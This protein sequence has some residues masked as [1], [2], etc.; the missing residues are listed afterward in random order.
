VAHSEIDLSRA[1][2]AIT[3]GAR[4]IGRATALAFARRG[5]RVAIGDLDVE[6]AREAAAAI[7]QATEATGHSTEPL[8]RPIEALGHATEALA[9]DVTS[10]DSF[11]A[12]VDAVQER[13]GPI[14]VLV[15][16]AGIMPAGRFLDETA[17][18]T[19]AILDVNLRGPIFGMQLV[20][21]GMIGRGRGHVIN[22]SSGAGRFALPGL[23]TYCASKHGLV[24][25]STTVARELA[26]TGVTVTAVLPSAVHTELSSGI[27]FPFARLAKVAPEDVA[28]AILD[29]CARRPIEVTVPR[30][31]AP[32]A[33]IAQLL[34][35]RLE[36]S[37]RRL[38]R[39]DRAIA[40]VDP[41]TR[42][43]YDARLA[44]Q[45]GS[46]EHAYQPATR[47]DDR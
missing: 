2:V 27:S 38:V 1:V 19:A 15:N 21:P 31:M 30:W 40:E 47:G 4:G 25:L 12:F 24:G 8:G 14:D 41:R 37:I 7:E 18:V 9:L 36:S 20:L 44:R 29:S 11:G 43:A 39:D 5:A 45:T 42:A 22:V 23:A 17:E 3:G 32:Y 34:P 13:C 33:P 46:R 6:V 10:A 26:G 35:K 16:N 28:D